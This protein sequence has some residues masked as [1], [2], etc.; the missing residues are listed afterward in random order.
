MPLADAALVQFHAGDA[1]EWEAQFYKVYHRSTTAFFTGLGPL[2]Q[3][4]IELGRTYY[5]VNDG[6]GWSDLRQKAADV[7]H[8]LYD[9]NKSFQREATPDDERLFKKLE[10]LVCEIV[11]GRDRTNRR[12]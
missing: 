1:T 7:L 12:P 3:R 6:Q 11:N 9:V 4:S 5:F 2:L 8:K 10:G